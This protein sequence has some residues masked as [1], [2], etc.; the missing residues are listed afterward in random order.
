MRG[1][2]TINVKQ[3]PCMAVRVRL[4]LK[5]SFYGPVWPYMAVHTSHIGLFTYDHTGHP[6][7]HRLHLQKTIPSQL[8]SRTLKQWLC[9]AV[10]TSHIGLFTYDH[11]G[12]TYSH[13]NHPQKTIPS[14]L[15]REAYIH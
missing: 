15:D 7:S 1:F 4:P 5:A 14:Q 11:T 2:S 3:W 10:H 12:H 8:D 9:M 6:Y 13:R